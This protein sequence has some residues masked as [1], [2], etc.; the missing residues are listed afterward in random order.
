[1]KIEEAVDFMSKIYLHRILDSYTKDTIKPD[2]E[3][4]RKRIISDKD[5][6]SEPKNIYQRFQLPE[7]SFDSRIL[8]NFL[9]EALLDAEDTA[10]PEP[11]L[12]AI[13]IDFEKRILEEASDADTFKFKDRETCKTY[14]TVLE[15][16]LRDDQISEDERNLLARLRTHLGL[17]FKDH[18][19]LQAALGKFPKP[20]NILHTEKEIKGEL[21]ELQKRGIVFFCNQCKE[22]PVYLIPDEIIE[23]IK[24]VMGF[25]LSD[26]AFNLLLNKL[27]LKSLKQILANNALPVSGKKED[28]ISRIIKA[29][30]M[31]SEALESLSI[32]ELYTLCKCLPGVQVSGS[33]AKR[34]SNIINHFDKL[35]I[36]E[37][38]ENA[39]PRLK[40]YEYYVELATRDRENLLSNKIIGKDK[41]MD[42]AFEEATRYLFE[43]K[44]G[45]PLE[46]T[47]GNEHADGIARFP[48]S[49]E[50]FM[51][52]TKSKETIYEFPNDHFN[53]FR[54]YIHN[55]PER[56]NCFLI[57]APEISEKSIENAYRL[58][59][60]SGMDTDVALISAADLKWV[61][62]NWGSFSQEEAFNLDVLN[63]TGILDRTSLKSR[64]KIFFK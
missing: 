6:L 16:A 10:L 52:D 53:Q 24:T 14:K 13:V 60:K 11:T 55:S 62:E 28:M 19:Y 23:G 32:E 51:W 7:R 42:N 40:F 45:I 50:L 38:D 57:I 47:A 30:I 3:T 18:F 5:L 64:M 43:K 37:T 59:I 25:E 58:K 34:I 61:A 12:I 33:K 4:A 31:P 27:T 46:T 20:G 29:E 15:V 63:F 44:L 8:S 22:G 17:T 39:D 49:K 9:L 56:V 36:V 1:M 41:D 26:K 48:K 21:A 2:E 54:R 35:R